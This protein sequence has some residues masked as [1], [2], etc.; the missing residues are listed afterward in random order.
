[1]QSP[2]IRLVW[3]L[4]AFGCGAPT[5]GVRTGEDAPAPP[6]SIN[7]M[8]FRDTPSTEFTQCGKAAAPFS[9]EVL[10]CMKSAMSERRPFV[11]L[12]ETPGLVPASRNPALVGAEFEGEFALRMYAVSG[13]GAGGRDPVDLLLT[14]PDAE[15]VQMQVALGETRHCVLAEAPPDPTDS[16][17][18]NVDQNGRHRFHAGKCLEWFDAAA[19]KDQPWALRFD[20]SAQLACAFE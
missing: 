10:A 11:V 20:S 17:W 6:C 2:A 12:M 16:G 18:V 15:A 7:G 8:L 9:G 4:V 14:S 19:W 5:P 13:D 3:A 1:V